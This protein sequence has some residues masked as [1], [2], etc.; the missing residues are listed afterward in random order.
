VIAIAICGALWWLGSS[1]RG[2]GVSGS[3]FA[4]PATRSPATP[5]TGVGASERAD[6]AALVRE[7]VET[8]ADTDATNPASATPATVRGRCVDE[9][10]HPMAGCIVTLRGAPA[11]DER[12]TDWTLQHGA[13]P[14]WQDPEP[15][16]TGDDGAFAFRF[17]PPPPFQ[18]ALAVGREGYARNHFTLNRLEPAEQADVGDVRMVRGVHLHGTLVDTNGRPVAGKR[19]QLVLRLDANGWIQKFMPDWGGNLTTASDGTFAFEQRLLPGNYAVDV[20]QEQLVEPRRVAVPPTE[21]H[22][23]RIVIEPPGELR[24]LRGR[25]V[26]DDGAPIARADVFAQATDWWTSSRAD[27]DGHF[28]VTC[29]VDSKDTG[30]TIQLRARAADHE[31]EGP[32]VRSAW[33]S[34]DVE[35][36]LHRCGTLTLRV[37]DERGV[38]VEQYAAHLAPRDA[39]T[40]GARRSSKPAAVHHPDGIAE[41]TGLQQGEWSV[42]VAFAPQTDRALLVH[43]LTCRDRSDL[44]VDLTATERAAR[45]LRVVDG[46]DRPVAGAQIDVCVPKQ[47][48]M[49]AETPVMPL[50]DWLRNSVRAALVH[51]R[52]ATGAD[53]RTTMRGPPDEGVAL[54]IEADGHRV[55]VVEPVRLDEPGELVVQLERG[56]GLAGRVTPPAVLDYLRRAA[57]LDD[58]AWFERQHPHLRL[59]RG[60]ERWPTK[61]FWVVGERPPLAIEADGTFAAW[62]LPT[63]T[64]Q[65]QLESYVVD[66]NTA[67]TTSL[68]LGEVTLVEGERTQRDLSLEAML[69]GRLQGL[70]LQNDRPAAHTSIVLHGEGRAQST[71][72]DASGRFDVELR[73]GTYGLRIGSLR[74][75][76]R[77]AVERDLVTEHT[78]RVSSGT[79]AVTLRDA[80][81]APAAEVDL[82]VPPSRPAHFCTDDNGYAEVEIE[83]REVTV[84][85]L[86]RRLQTDE[87]MLRMHAEAEATGRANPFTPYLI[88]VG[89]AT[90]TAGERTEVELT[91]PADY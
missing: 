56:A 69:P 45:T 15:Q 81:G 57:G 50:S 82:H 7:Q 22:H 29:P 39:E 62:G 54:R 72:T 78:F 73:P 13:P 44:R 11:S 20:P 63:G 35:L 28:E 86:P 23:V 47:P 51:E 24:R 16:R 27:D 10:G 9:Q 74:S 12:M 88:E 43:R 18:F 25:V 38:P 53:G 52:S 21:A 91:L 85:V 36:V 5:A 75:F 14:E 59:V 83:A 64:W 55:Q 2:P 6:G 40:A 79:L 42:V 34:D 4:D 37:T 30:E 60:D 89:R 67:Q 90:V 77:A 33:N 31:F 41:L 68:P 17:R 84:M 26:D 48:A 8:P 32:P 49:H 80:A 1:A 19:V 3:P 65:V 61:P 66:G 46:E 71:N 58:G 76:D 70:V 87:Q